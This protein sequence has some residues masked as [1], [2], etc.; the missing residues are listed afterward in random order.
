MQFLRQVDE[1]PFFLRQVEGL[2]DQVVIVPFGR[3]LEGRITHPID[4]A[5]DCPGLLQIDVRKH[6]ADVGESQRV[7]G[8]RILHMLEDRGPDGLE[9]AEVL[10]LDP[11]GRQRGRLV[12][13]LDDLVQRVEGDG[14]IPEDLVSRGGPGQMLFETDDGLRERFNLGDVQ[15]FFG[16]GTTGLGRFE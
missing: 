14:A 11:V 9:L 4:V 8:P 5:P 2:P 1:I 12:H 10:G 7:Q 6:R 3:R 16:R 13:I 15:A